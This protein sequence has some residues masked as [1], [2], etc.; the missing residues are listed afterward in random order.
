MG[1]PADKLAVIIQA[2]T[3]EMTLIIDTY[4]GYIL[5]YVG[6]AILAFFLVSES[7]EY[8]IPCINAITC[9]QSMI[10]VIKNGINPILNQY[11]YPEIN[12]RIGIDIG[13]NVVVQFGFDIYSRKESDK[14]EDYSIKI[15]HL[16]ILGYTIS[17]ASKMTSLGHPDQIIIGELVYNALDD[18]HK[19]DFKLIHVNP[20]I[21]S[22]VS[23]NT[24]GIYR[25]YGS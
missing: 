24:G 1:L 8:Y 2:F 4:G 21:W 6:D 20:E 11:G 22:Y 14:S 7:S 3:H 12:S 15:P 9:A 17:I 23:D 19:E 5:K 13:E 25:L 18:I 10:Q 16:D